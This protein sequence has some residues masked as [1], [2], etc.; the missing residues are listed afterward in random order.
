M[1][2]AHR[3]VAPAHRANCPKWSF[4]PYALRLSS[5]PQHLASQFLKLPGLRARPFP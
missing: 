5:A 1:Q 2:M 3:G 4:P